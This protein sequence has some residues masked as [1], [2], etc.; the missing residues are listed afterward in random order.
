MRGG[1]FAGL[2]ALN[3]ALAVALAVLWQDAGRVQWTAPPP[4]EPALNYDLAVAAAQTVE[5]SQYRETIER[6]LFIAT[7]RPAV[8][9]AKEEAARVD[10][11]K[12]LRL[13]G[14]YGSGD[15]GGVIVAREGKVERVAVGDK[16]AGWTVA[17]TET[18]GATLV[19]GSG[20]RR[21]L[22]VGLINTAPAAVASVAAAAAG[23]AA[24]TGGADPTAA[25]AA[26]APPA[27]ASAGARARD[28]AADGR[29]A[30]RNRRR[31]EVQ[32]WSGRSINPPPR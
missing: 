11:L 18:S 12:D 19:D 24:R 22:R 27:A 13:L 9:A 17:S 14:L 25:A 21:E 8:P 31:G 29:A 10:A 32:R 16:I 23:G 20:E 3:V 5:I 7:R 1:A 28:G 15:R 4:I 2:A 30:D 26:G 6:P